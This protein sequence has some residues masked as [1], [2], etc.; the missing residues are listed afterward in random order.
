MSIDELLVE[1]SYRT[2]KGYPDLGNPSDILILKSLLEDLKL[3][4]N[5]I[6]SNLGEASLNPGQLAKR[7]N[8]EIFLNKIFNNEEFELTNGDK[9]IIDPNRKILTF[10][11]IKGNSYKLN[12]FKKTT[13]FGGKEA[14]SSDPKKPTVDTD[15]KESLV[16]LFCNI[17][18]E[19]GNL[20]PFNAGTYSNNFNIINSSTTK[21]T[22]IENT[23]KNKIEQ[24]FN[25]I[26]T[27]DKPLKKVRSVLNNPYSIAKE[28][29]ET[30]PNAR[31][32]RGNLFN[33]IRAKCSKI[34]GLEKD[35]WN[36]GDIY[37]VNYNPKLPD[38]E[39][40][41][42]PWNALFVNN[43]GDVDSPLV[44]I[45][46][47]EEKYQPG[48]A[49][50]YLKQF[51]NEEGKVN[52]DLNNDELEFSEDQYKEGILSFRKQIVNNLEDGGL[53]SPNEVKF[54]GDGW[55]NFSDNIKTLR[56]KYGAYKLLHFILNK[57]NQSSVLG[58][59]AYG[60][61][62]PG[63]P[64]VNP[65]FFKLVGR[66]EGDKAKNEPFP[67]GSNTIMTKEEPV[68]IVDSSKAA[69]LTVKSKIDIVKDG[70]IIETGKSVSK[71]FR[72]SGSGPVKSIGIV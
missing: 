31:F 13:E 32:N 26:S 33:T 5:N 43:W 60:L 25:L 61:S 6:I 27:T 3:P 70:E 62:I 63:N 65:T 18:K 9:I 42:V 28:I 36:P 45:S 51:T 38:N 44:S 11:D 17:L 20:Q 37:L 64:S 23:V 34:T 53:G 41:I 4:S 55:E 49:K 19:G 59:F 7:N 69:N 48:R 30:Y 14:V 29:I 57:K 2:K 21:Y 10:T 8:F 56:I 35:K 54:E 47:K 46:L 24:L 52:Y 40:S 58:L 72:T 71:T 39:D 50:S 68:V 16:I 66:N 12:K 15:V 1:W 67:G 22:D